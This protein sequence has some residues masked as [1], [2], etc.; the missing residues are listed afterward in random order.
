MLGPHTPVGITSSLG[1]WPNEADRIK[2]MRV[3]AQMHVTF[4]EVVVQ[5]EMLIPSCMSVYTC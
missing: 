5:I 3:L 1:T 4:Q 2:Y